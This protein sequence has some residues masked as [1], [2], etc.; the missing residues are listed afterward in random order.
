MRAP[1]A[2]TTFPHVV[3]FIGGGVA[4][5]LSSRAKFDPKTRVREEGGGAS[6]PH[7]AHLSLVRPK[8]ISNF[9]CYR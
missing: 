3:V 2:N 6:L 8:E 4:S 7:I 5:T 1:K 9:V